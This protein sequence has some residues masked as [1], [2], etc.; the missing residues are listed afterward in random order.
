MTGITSRLPGFRRT[1]ARPNIVRECSCSSEISISCR[2][3]LIS[4]P[5]LAWSRGSALLKLN[6]TPLRQDSSQNGGLRKW[7][8]FA[9]PSRLQP[10]Q[11]IKWVLWSRRS[12]RT[13]DVCLDSFIKHL[14]PASHPFSQWMTAILT[15]PTINFSRSGCPSEEV[16]VKLRSQG[17]S[18]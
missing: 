10:E 5:S 14:R 17:S 16:V 11:T 18:G 3:L 1:P 7:R 8:R 4:F 12:L 2:S 13:S 9:Y 6:S 15:V